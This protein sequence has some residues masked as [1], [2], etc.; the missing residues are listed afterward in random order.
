M[1][2]LKRLKCYW[3]GK[4]EDN[5][6]GYDDEGNWYCNECWEEYEEQSLTN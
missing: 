4:E 1:S 2:K 6:G 3:C 5:E